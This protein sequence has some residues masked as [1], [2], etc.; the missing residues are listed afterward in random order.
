MND[1]LSFYFS[2]DVHNPKTV[3]NFKCKGNG[4]EGE[5]EG[6]EEFNFV[7]EKADLQTLFEETEIIKKKLDRIVASG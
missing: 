4:G 5:G 1:K 6:L 2:E 3:M 7:F